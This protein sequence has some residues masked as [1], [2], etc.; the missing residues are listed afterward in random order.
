M[1]YLYLI[2]FMQMLVIPICIYIYICIY[3][4]W[5]MRVKVVACA[6]S[7]T[8]LISSAP[9]PSSHLS[10]TLPSSSL[11]YAPFLSHTESNNDIIIV[12]I[13]ICPTVRLTIRMSLLSS[14]EGGPEIRN[15]WF[16]VVFVDVMMVM[17]EAFI[18]SL[19]SCWWWCYGFIGIHPH[20]Y[21]LVGD[22]V[23]A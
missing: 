22:G 4:R 1:K 15:A 12:F 18:P 21:D 3:R 10:A 8:I 14:R 17:M 20:H 6:P 7:P 5:R 2:R 23:E 13:R 16:D 11:P 9:S 19:W